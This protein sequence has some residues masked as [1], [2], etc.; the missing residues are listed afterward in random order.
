MR[1]LVE[2]MRRDRHFRATFRW[3]DRL[4]FE[5]VAPQRAKNGAAVRLGTQSSAF[6]D[7]AHVPAERGVEA[8]LQAEG[9]DRCRIVG[10]AGDNDVE[11][12]MAFQRFEKRLCAHLRDNGRRCID[13]LLVERLYWPTWDDPAAAQLIRDPFLGNLRIDRRRTKSIAPGS[14]Y[15]PDDIDEDVD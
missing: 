8:V 15:L 4:Q 9:G 5:M 1:F 11:I 13:L 12:A 14:R 3:I 7:L 6:H 2:R 10:A